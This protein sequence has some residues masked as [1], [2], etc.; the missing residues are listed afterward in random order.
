[1]PGASERA[2]PA[3]CGDGGKKV[4][5]EGQKIPPPRRW[6]E[7]QNPLVGPTRGMGLGSIQPNRSSIPL[8][9]QVPGTTVRQATWLSWPGVRPPGPRP[10]MHTGTGLQ[11]RDSAGL[12]A[13]GGARAD[14]RTSPFQPC[15]SARAPHRGSSVVKLNIPQTASL[16]RSAFPGCVSR[17]SGRLIS[18]ANLLPGP[19]PLA[20]PPSQRPV[21]PKSYLC[22]YIDSSQRTQRTQRFFLFAALR[23]LQPRRFKQTTSRRMGCDRTGGNNLVLWKF[24]LLGSKK[25]CRALWLGSAWHVPPNKP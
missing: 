9:S 23:S 1:V 19:F 7:N 25:T 11:L 16:A 6:G 13:R 17:S 24:P 15:L 12:S 3:P 8:S 14:H 20:P 4:T 5:C 10:D 18:L 21:M 22:G 2:W